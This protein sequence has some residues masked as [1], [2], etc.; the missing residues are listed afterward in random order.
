MSL[1]CLRVRTKECLAKIRAQN[2]EVHESWNVKQIFDVISRSSLPVEQ[3]TWVLCD[4]QLAL[5][6]ALHLYFAHF[7]N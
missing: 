1:V 6:Q 3:K 2:T 5:L 4:L 7:L